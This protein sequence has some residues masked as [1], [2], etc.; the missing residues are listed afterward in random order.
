VRRVGCGS[1]PS[2]DPRRHLLVNGLLVADSFVL[3]LFDE[4]GVEVAGARAEHPVG[5]GPRSGPLGL[6]LLR[7][8]F[9]LIQRSHSRGVFRHSSDARD[10]ADVTHPVC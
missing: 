8:A 2:Y 10:P 5:H 6:K 7:Q 3:E 1:W 4:P 9:V